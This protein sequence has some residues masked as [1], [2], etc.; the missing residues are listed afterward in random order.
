MA[1]V[2]TENEENGRLV[3]KSQ[4]WYANESGISNVIWNV[5]GKQIAVLA[6]THPGFQLALIGELDEYQDVEAQGYSLISVIPNARAN[7]CRICF[8]LILL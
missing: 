2:V 8:H 4:I 5:G 1:E 6:W 7:V 3:E